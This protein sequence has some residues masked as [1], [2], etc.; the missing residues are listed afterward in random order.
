MFSLQRFLSKS[1]RFFDLLEA[2]AD[3]SHGAVTA[4]VSMLSAKHSGQTLDDFVARRKQ[5]K[6][7][8][9]DMTTLLCSSF[10]TPLEREDIEALSSALYKIPKSVE[11]FCEGLFLTPQ[12][13][14]PEMFIKQVHILEKS[15]EAL[16]EMVRQLRHHPNL[17]KI[18][19][20]NETLHHLEGEADKLILEL[21]REL[22]SGK[23]EP[24]Q[25]IILRDLYE[26][27]EKIIDRCRTAGNVIFQ[28]VLKYS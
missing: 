9:E 7:L 19:N 20:H 17:E 6:R 15:T 16:C 14:Q 22:Y 24:L 27:L 12:Y 11:K 21:L 18:K 25:V 4:L 26:N 10:V 5:N 13:W 8:F 1:G 28:I 2:G 3:A 23:Y